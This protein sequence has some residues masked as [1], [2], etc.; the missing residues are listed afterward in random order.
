MVIN[1]EQAAGSEIARL[2]KFPPATNVEIFAKGRVEMV[3]IN[4]TNDMAIS[5][6]QLKNIETDFLHQF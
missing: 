3:E 2:I 1:P 4:V 6:M 5:N